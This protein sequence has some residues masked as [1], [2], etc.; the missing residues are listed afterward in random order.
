MP[1]LVATTSTP[2]QKP[3]V[4]THYV[5]TNGFVSVTSSQ[6]LT[7]ITNIL[8]DSV[9]PENRLYV[10]RFSLY[11]YSGNDLIGLKVENCYVTL[12]TYTVSLPPARGRGDEEGKFRG[13]QRYLQ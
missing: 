12:F 5:R 2:A 7:F 10:A 3:F 4:R 1:S 13:C 9:L 6:V 11:Q 8:V